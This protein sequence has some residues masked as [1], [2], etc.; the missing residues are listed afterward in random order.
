MLKALP[1]NIL[2]NHPSYD[3]IMSAYNDLLKEKGKVN[4]KKFYETVILKEIPDYDMGSWYYFLKRFKTEAGIT[5]EI[6]IVPSPTAPLSTPPETQVAKTMLS[7][8][9]A[10]VAL[11]SGI[12]NISAKAA[13]DIIEHPELLSTKDR[14]EI[15]MKAM[16]AQDSRIHAVG[17]LR[18]DNRE[19]ERFDR[20]FSSSQF[21]E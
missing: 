21:G 9:E 2:V 1:T 14:L 13:K 6:E 18:E 11:I 12:L 4:N 5:K 3:K 15:G 8:Q 7:N 10:T 20:A 17:K 19:Q 16:K